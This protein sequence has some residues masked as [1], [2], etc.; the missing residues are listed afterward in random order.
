MG[1]V[2][3]FRTRSGAG[4]AKTEA[5][6]VGEAV[7]ISLDVA[8]MVFRPRDSERRLTQRDSTDDAEE[9]ALREFFLRDE[10]LF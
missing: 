4:L 5:S 2:V 9:R 8:R 6:S 3:P 1:R 7:V 10:P